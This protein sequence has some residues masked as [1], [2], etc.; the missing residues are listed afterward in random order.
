[1]QKMR[2]VLKY[3]SYSNA[4]RGRWPFTKYIHQ[5]GK[6]KQPSRCQN[7]MSWLA[8]PVCQNSLL[9]PARNLELGPD[10][11]GWCRNRNKKNQAQTIV[12]R[13]NTWWLTWK[14]RQA[15]RCWSNAGKPDWPA[16]SGVKGTAA[17]Q[18]CWQERNSSVEPGRDGERESE[19]HIWNSC[20]QTK[21]DGNMYPAQSG[22]VQTT[23]PPWE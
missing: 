1:M 7:K 16:F 11:K 14:Q 19:D 23:A 13:I 3:Q 18:S 15:N 10:E 12:C 21:K 9:T 6:N 17:F 20:V 4:K 22:G 5:A 8:L 2:P